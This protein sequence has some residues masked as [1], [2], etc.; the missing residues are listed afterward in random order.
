MTQL[1]HCQEEDKQEY[2]KRESLKFLEIVV[3]PILFGTPCIC[4]DHMSYV[5]IHLGEDS[6]IPYQFLF[7]A[8]RR[9]RK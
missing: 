8:L 6:D 2:L 9:G 1:C 7:T 3:V 4:V 5:Y